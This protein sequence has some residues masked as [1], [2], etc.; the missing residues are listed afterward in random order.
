M[1][2]QDALYL[3]LYGSVGVKELKVLL[4][5][6]RLIVLLAMWKRCSIC[7]LFCIF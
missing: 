1:T 7:W 4:Y 3:Y 5:R 2:A 6:I